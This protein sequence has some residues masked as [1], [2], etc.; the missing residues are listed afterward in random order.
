[1]KTAVTLFTMIV[2]APTATVT[3]LVLYHPDRWDGTLSLGKI[4]GMAFFGLVTVPLWFTYIPALIFAPIII[5]RITSHPAFFSSPLPIFISV[6]L[7]AGAVAGICVLLPVIAPAAF[8]SR[9]LALNW[10][11]AGAVSGGIS[12]LI[13][14]T[15]SRFVD[16][17][18]STHKP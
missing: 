8:D 9:D 15:S 4:V 2:I 16:R 12:S 10:L 5:R 13:I 11:C 17:G 7:F 1:M 3:T 6:A 14:G 18:A